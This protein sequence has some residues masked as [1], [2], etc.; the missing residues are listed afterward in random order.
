LR[1]IVDFY[2]RQVKPD[3]DFGHNKEI[4]IKNYRLYLIKDPV[5]EGIDEKVR[6]LLVLNKGTTI[7]VGNSILKPEIH[8]FSTRVSNMLPDIFP[9]L[10]D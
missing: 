8:K 3:K 10:K 4:M 7:H 9:V 5:A 2:K 6:S 1:Q